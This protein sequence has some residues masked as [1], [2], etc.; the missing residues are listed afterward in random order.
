MEAKLFIKLT[1]EETKDIFDEYIRKR[2][3]E[4]VDLAEKA[5]MDARLRDLAKGEVKEDSYYYDKLK[6]GNL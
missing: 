2:K 6:Q 3:Q 5:I 1:E 4:L